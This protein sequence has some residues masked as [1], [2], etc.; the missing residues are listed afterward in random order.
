VLQAA[1]T[2]GLEGLRIVVVGR[3]GEE[4]TRERAS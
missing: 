1:E 3:D 2:V 4:I